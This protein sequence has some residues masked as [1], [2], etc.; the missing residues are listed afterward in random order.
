[1]VAPL[2]TGPAWFLVIVVLGQVVVVVGALYLVWQLWATV[3]AFLQGANTKKAELLGEILGK[4]SVEGRQGKDS[5]KA[6]GMGL[7][8]TV[9]L[10]LAAVAAAWVIGQHTAK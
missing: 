3:I 1:M 9:L 5:L 10:M 2:G 4:A 6:V 8:L 7:G